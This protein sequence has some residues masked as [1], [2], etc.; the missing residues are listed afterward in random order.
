M[1][2]ARSGLV[3]FVDLV[4]VMSGVMRLIGSQKCTGEMLAVIVKVH[5]P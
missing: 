1:C 2:A 5:A 4:V 3:W